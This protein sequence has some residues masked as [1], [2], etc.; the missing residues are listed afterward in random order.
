M[1]P[2]WVILTICEPWKIGPNEAPRVTIIVHVPDRWE[3]DIQTKSVVKFHGQP[4]PDPPG[5]CRR[6]GGGG[7]RE[8]QE[9]FQLF[10]P[11]FGHFKPPH[12]SFPPFLDPLNSFPWSLFAD[13]S[14]FE[15][16]NENKIG[17]RLDRVFR[18]PQRLLAQGND[19][20]E[21]LVSWD[22]HLYVVCKF[23]TSFG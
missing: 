11:F 23:W 5:S 19:T 14:L 8:S 18:P 13:S 20:D 9:V 22:F 6:S 15:S 4:P 2:S 12:S 10:R 16:Y 3:E 7:H 21:F 1:D 17:R